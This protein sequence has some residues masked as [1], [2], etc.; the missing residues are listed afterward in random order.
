MSA[1]VPLQVR[2]SEYLAER[3]RLGYALHAQ[4]TLLADFARFVAEQQHEGPLT[5]SVMVVWAQ[6]AR[7]GR[8][9][10]ET[11]YRRMQRL[12]PF[13]HYLQQFEPQTEIPEDTIFGPEPK[14]VAPHIY[15][16]EEIVALLDAA[17]HAKVTELLC[18]LTASDLMQ[19][20]HTMHAARPQTEFQG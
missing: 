16:E 15:R 18:E 19:V 20:L 11:W 6:Q 7:A 9:T 4:D 2:V 1:S 10:R 14:R 17:A 12:R 3:R 13:V 5:V 8:G